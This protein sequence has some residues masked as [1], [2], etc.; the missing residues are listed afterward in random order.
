M[1]TTEELKISHYK[2]YKCFDFLVVANNKIEVAQAFVKYRRP[3]YFLP[4]VGVEFVSLTLVGKHFKLGKY[5]VVVLRGEVHSETLRCLLPK[6]TDQPIGSSFLLLRPFRDVGNYCL[7]LHIL[8]SSKKFTLAMQFLCELIDST[9]KE[10]EDVFRVLVYASDELLD[11][12]TYRALIGCSWELFRCSPGE[13]CNCPDMC[14][15]QHLIEDSTLVKVGIGIDGD[16]VKLFHDYGLLKPNRIR[17][18]N[19][20]VHP[21]SKQQLQYAATDAYASWHLHQVL[22]DLPDAV[23]GS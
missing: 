3:E 4:L 8:P 5:S 17:L 15:L 20:E 21:L 12:K 13:G 19:W 23:S 2:L 22:K 14:R 1:D 16:S 18:G 7:L 11:V 10:E 6:L 9:S